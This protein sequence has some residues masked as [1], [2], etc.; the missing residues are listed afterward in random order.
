[1]TLDKKTMLK[2]IGIIAAAALIFTAFQNIGEVI[3]FL[4]SIF[5]FLCRL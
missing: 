5:R 1:M 4:K 3:V 2:I